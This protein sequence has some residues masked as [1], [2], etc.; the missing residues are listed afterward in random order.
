M[1]EYLSRQ[2]T[3]KIRHLLTSSLRA[4]SNGHT[5]VDMI[6]SVCV[7]PVV[8][9]CESIRRDIQVYKV[10]SGAF[11]NYSPRQE[12]KVWKIADI[13]REESKSCSLYK[14]TALT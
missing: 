12:F 1:S 3:D 7:V 8:E 4:L 5:N 11:N 2:Q 13:L 9:K 10:L 6:G 14:R